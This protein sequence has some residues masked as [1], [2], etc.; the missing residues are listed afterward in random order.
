[1]RDECRR[2]NTLFAMVTLTRGI[3]VS[4]SLETKERLLRQLGVKDL[5][6]PERR[7]EAFGKR[8]GIPV[9]TLA[10]RMAET[11]VERQVFYHAD[12]GVPGTGHWTRD[13]HK[14]AGELI[15][16]WL[17]GELADKWRQAPPR[18]MTAR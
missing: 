13:G 8:E 5:Y 11:A 3:Q 9:L 2:K 7:L 14:A 4:P 18:P 17:A 6:Y 15:S 1:M 12:H 16:S 10:P